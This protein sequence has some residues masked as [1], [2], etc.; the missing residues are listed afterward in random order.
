LDDAYLGRGRPLGQARVLWEIG[1]DGC[2]V[3]ELRSRLELDSGYVSRLLRALESSGLVRVEPSAADGRVRIAR[4]TDLGVAER[5]LLDE[6]SDELAASILEPLSERQRERLV[7]AMDEVSRLLDAAA[8]RIAVVDPGTADAQ[9]CLGEYFAELGRRFDGGFDHSRSISAENHELTLPAGLLLM[10]T[11]HGEPVGCGGLKFHGDEPAEV[12]R[13]WVSPTA[14]GLGVG[15][16]LLVELEREASAHQAPA[17][18]LETNR[19]LVEAIAMYR[20]AGYQEVPAF[21]S[22]PYAHHWFEK[23]L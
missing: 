14:R 3:R 5:A 19:S 22:E 1:A 6:R 4:L 20:A 21:N 8:V 2:D 16:R 13:M 10:A 11:L 23:T 9:Y 17:V 15:R 18:R 7:A 12:K